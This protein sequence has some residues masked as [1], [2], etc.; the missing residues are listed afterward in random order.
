M[1]YGTNLLPTATSIINQTK[2]NCLCQLNWLAPD[3]QQVADAMVLESGDA[4]ML[5]QNPGY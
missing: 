2:I 4:K 5:T 3:Q 1:D